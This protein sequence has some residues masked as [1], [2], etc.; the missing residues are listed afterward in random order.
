VFVGGHAAIVEG[1]SSDPLM[2]LTSAVA[3][4]H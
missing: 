3:G 2:T 1:F 4:R